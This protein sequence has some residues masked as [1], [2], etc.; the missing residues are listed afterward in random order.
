MAQMITN[1]IKFFLVILIAYLAFSL[2]FAN[3]VTTP[4]FS[5]VISDGWEVS[6]PVTTEDEKLTA[7]FTN[8]RTKTVVDVEIQPKGFKAELDNLGNAL[9]MLGNQLL[10]DVDQSSFKLAQ[11]YEYATFKGKGVAGITFITKN[12]DTQ[13]VINVY[14]PEHGDGVDFVNTFFKK[15]E[16]LFPEFVDPTVPPN[17]LNYILLLR[18]AK[19]WVHANLTPSEWF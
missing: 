13:A 5:V 3:R 9:T 18:Q 12:D 7:S 19:T 16:T 2:T 11:G 15:D 6:K 8:K 14:G 10:N 17:A 4:Y 1:I